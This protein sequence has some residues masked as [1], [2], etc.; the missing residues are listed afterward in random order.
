MGSSGIYWSFMSFFSL[1]DVM[2]I[3][4]CQCVCVCVRI[5]FLLVTA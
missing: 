3:F 4:P 5:L 1:N 2:N